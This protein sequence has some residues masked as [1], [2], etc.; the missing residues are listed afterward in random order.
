MRL[1]TMRAD[2]RD[3]HRPLMMHMSDRQHTSRWLSSLCKKREQK[4]LTARTF[5][6]SVLVNSEA[7]L[8]TTNS[9]SSS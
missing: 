9:P 1:G 5:D 8:I 3:E 7:C 6:S 4:Q 2:Q